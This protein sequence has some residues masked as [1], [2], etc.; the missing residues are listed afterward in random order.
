MSTNEGTFKPLSARAAGNSESSRAQLTISGLRFTLPW[1]AAGC[2][3]RQV[4]IR[5]RD[6][7]VG[8]VPWHTCK[9]LLLERFSKFQIGT[10]GRGAE[11]MYLPRSCCTKVTS[12]Q[13]QH[14]YQALTCT[15]HYFRTASEILNGFDSAFGRTFP[16]NQRQLTAGCRLDG[17]PINP[18]HVFRWPGTTAV[19]FHDKFRLFHGF[20][21]HVLR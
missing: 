17:S 18:L 1:L 5:R 12:N 14:N 7:C 10:V 9:K 13:S 15:G 2:C 6:C 11:H 3:L 21:L 16:H 4:R 19:N 8:A 20:S